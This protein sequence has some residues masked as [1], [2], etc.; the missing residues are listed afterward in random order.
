MPHEDPR[1]NHGNWQ[2]SRARPDPP[3]ESPITWKV[4]IVLLFIGIAIAVAILKA[5]R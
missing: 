3:P 5:N 2:A 1:P 4:A